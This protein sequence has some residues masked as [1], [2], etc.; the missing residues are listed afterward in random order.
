MTIN[1][2][3][4][5]CWKEFDCDVGKIGIDDSGM[6]PIFEKGIVCPWCDKLIMDDVF[7]P[8]H[9]LS[10]YKVIKGGYEKNRWMHDPD[11]DDETLKVFNELFTKI[12]ENGKPQACRSHLAFQ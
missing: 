6:R 7:L 12:A 1:F 4:K 2:E 10:Y 3:C 5:K 9:I 8:T 11:I